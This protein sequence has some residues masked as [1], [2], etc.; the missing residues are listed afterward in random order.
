MSVSRNTLIT[1]IVIILFGW[2]MTAFYYA[3]IDISEYLNDTSRSTMFE[4]NLT[5]LIAFACLV[6]ILSFIGFSKKKKK[7]WAKAL[8]LPDEFEENDEREKQITS[9]HAELLTLA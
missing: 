2:A 1:V 4:L 5:P 9:H 6:G 7:S 3:S 8:L